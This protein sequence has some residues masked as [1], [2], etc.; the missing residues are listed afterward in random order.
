[1][2]RELEVLK[3]SDY[4]PLQMTQKQIKKHRKY[5]FDA[6]FVTGMGLEPIRLATPPPQDGESTNSST[7]PVLDFYWLKCS[8]IIRHFDSSD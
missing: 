7:R 6:F 4:S 5:I 3:K 2:Y 8:K 1:M